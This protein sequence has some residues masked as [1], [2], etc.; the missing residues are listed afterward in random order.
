MGEMDEI[1]RRQQGE[2]D[3]AE[4]RLNRQLF[5]LT[6]FFAWMGILTLATFFSIAVEN[7][8]TITV[9]PRK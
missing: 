3:E 1:D 7:R 9:E 8:I 4:R 5:A 6:I 2:I